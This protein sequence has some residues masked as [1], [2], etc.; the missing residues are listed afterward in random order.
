MLLEKEMKLADVISHDYNLIPV[1]GRFGIMLG[2]G[3]ESIENICNNKGVNIDF[4]LTILNTFHDPQYLDKNHLQTFSA[5]QIVEYLQ[6]AHSYYLQNKIPEIE[7]LINDMAK[8]NEVDATSHNLLHNF[9]EN[10]KN[11]FVKHIEKEEN[12]VY[13]YVINLENSKDN[14]Y[15][16]NDLHLQIKEHSITKYE[17]EHENVEET[18]TDLKNILIKY[19]PSSIKQ[20]NRYRLL[21]ELSA[22]EKDLHDHAQLEN[23]ILVPKVETLEVI[24]TEKQVANY[25]N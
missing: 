19:L 12:I 20:Q 15:I 10:Y 5:K 14:N 16:S 25:N 6:K 18:L 3:D 22:L 4:F 23:L 13:P 11:E 21:K 8:N 1:I 7:N 2:F 24:I 9:F 17:A